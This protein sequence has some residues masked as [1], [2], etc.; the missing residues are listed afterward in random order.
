MGGG[1]ERSKRR[2]EG[3]LSVYMQNQ[4]SDII[5]SGVDWAIEENKEH[6][7]KTCETFGLNPKIIPEQ[8]SASA[9]ENVKNSSKL[10]DEGVEEIVL[11]TESTHI[12]EV[13][14][15]AK[16]FLDGYKLGFYAV[17]EK[18]NRYLPLHL[19]ESI[20]GFS[21]SLMPEYADS[22]ISRY[23]K[24]LKSSAKKEGKSL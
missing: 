19:I 3:A 4:D 11:V 13:K 6:I 8:E 14:R 10:I 22:L 21:F 5:V 23:W 16:R 1:V 2:F 20:I 17:P 9:L 18:L 12:A 15:Y 7:K 24:N